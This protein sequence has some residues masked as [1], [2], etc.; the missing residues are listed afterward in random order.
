MTEQPISCSGSG[1][2]LIDNTF[3]SSGALADALA[4]GVAAQLARAI[5]ARGAGGLAVSGGTTPVAFFHALSHHRLA[6]DK[7]IITLVDERWADESSRRS[8][9]RLVRENLLQ[10]AATAAT[11]VPLFGSGSTP[12]EGLAAA[13]LRL[14]QVPA[15]F[16]AVILGMGDDGHTASFFPGG[17]NL[18]AAIDPLNAVAL[19]SMRADGA[20]EA[21]IT[22]TL[23]R[24]LHSD[25]LALHIE[26]DKK[27]AVLAEALGQGP[28]TAMPVRAVLRQQH[29][30]VHLYWCPDP[31][32]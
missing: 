9:A 7:V 11:F 15:P 21:R 23:A 27:R 26:G 5:D 20:G 16:S 17:D 12:E 28:E 10:N 1:A 18:E 4:Q 30:P 25:F 32:D 13:N 19:T 22:L 14:N 2:N 24:L 6:W 29:L 3:A 31:P 8:N